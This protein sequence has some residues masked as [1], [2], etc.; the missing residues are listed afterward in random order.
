MKQIKFGDIL[1]VTEGIIVHGCNAQ[2]VM[3]SGIAL[4]IKN[5]YPEVYQEYTD[6]FKNATWVPRDLLGSAQVV[7]IKS[8]KPLYVVNGITQENFG[9]D[10]AKYVS[11]QAI[12]MVFS[13][14]AMMA[15]SNS[16]DVHYPMIGAGLG[17]GDW[18]I[19]SDIID[20]TFSQ[21]PNVNHN[22]W[23]LE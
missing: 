16:L 13:Q 19:I 22:L 20:T 21:Y 9:R 12:Q 1:S 2:G 5:K 10:G 14:V 8:N 4:A 15:S 11:Y 23:I 3:G 7:K 17:G 18:A 6:A